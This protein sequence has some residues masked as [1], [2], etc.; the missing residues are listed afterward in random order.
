MS[1]KTF[2][3]Q[4]PER[5]PMAR[6]EA[7]QPSGHPHEKLIQL[8][9]ILGN[10]AVSRMIASGA[11]PGVPAG[12]ISPD[13]TRAIRRQ[14]PNPAGGPPPVAAPSTLAFGQVVHVEVR[15]SGTVEP[16]THEYPIDV[17]GDI[18]MP[19]L[20]LVRANGLTT[21]QLA[22]TIQRRLVTGQIF[23]SP[24]VNVT[25]TSK[26]VAYGALITASRVHMRL[27]GADGTVEPESG[28]Y[29]IRADGTL[30]LP[31]VGTVQARGRRLDEVEAEIQAGYR[32]SY[33]NN[34]VVHLTLQ[35]LP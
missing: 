3:T 22:D 16:L 29:P 8:Q 23:H 12:R 35:R 10:G 14:A 11:A 5:E 1:G 2:A 24:T 7:P 31:Y 18:K 32:R 27:L 21:D 6:T 28:D 9:Q 17:N 4:A 25:L 26:I 30:N 20:G 34:A 13:P 15:S 33:I 19:M